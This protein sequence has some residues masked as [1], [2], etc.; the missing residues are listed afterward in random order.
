MK[1]SILVILMFFFQIHSYSQQMLGRWEN[2]TFTNASYNVKWK[3]DPELEMI[4]VGRKEKDEIFRAISSDAV[5]CA[6]ITISRNESPNYVSTDIWEG[7]AEYQ[8]GVKD[9]LLLIEKKYPSISNCSPFFRRCYF[10]AQKA[11]K[12]IYETKI[13]DDRYQKGE[14]DQMTYS[15]TYILGRN[16]I[17]VKMEARKSFMALEGANDLINEIFK[18]FSN[19][20]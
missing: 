4:P 1:K 9:G 5:V 16:M 12:T 20:N 17:C 3:F 18:G 19:I 7:Q 14:L 10:Q 13:I 2:S 11:L 15:Y 8:K 6:S